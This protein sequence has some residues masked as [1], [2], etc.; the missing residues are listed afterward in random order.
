MSSER[1]ACQGG[2]PVRRTPM[3]GWPHF[4]ADEIA[5]V[6]EILASGK[7]NYWTG[8]VGRQ[9]EQ[10]YAEYLGVAHAIT[11]ANG[12]VALELG[13]RAFGVGPGDEVVVPAKTFIASASAVVAVGGVPVVADVDLVSQNLTAETIAAVLTPRTRAIV[14]VHLGG[15]PADMSAIMAF[16]EAR[17]LLVIEDC[18]Q[19][20]GATLG[21]R[22]VGSFG[23]CAAFSFCQDKIIT[24]GG[25][26]GMLAIRDDENAWQ[27][28]WA[29]KDH[30]K[31][32]DAVYHRAHPAGFRWLHESFGTNMR[33]PEPQAAIGR[34]QLAKLPVW[35]A[36]RAAHAE[37]LLAGLEGT[38]GLVLPVPPAGMEHAWY[39]CYLQLDLPRLGAGW[40]QTEIV[41]AVVAEGV[42][43]FAGSCSEIY[44]EKA[45]ANAGWGDATPLPNAVQLTQTSLALLVHPTL[46]ATDID[47]TVQAVRKVMRA[48]VEA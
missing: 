38:P 28:A 18:A 36:R 5:A 22:P 2:E 1:L 15:W 13:L 31:S 6:G 21:G 24:T 7:V 27:R 33:M 44:R 39:R 20:H 19:A 30:G 42:P 26:G 29:Y 47:D 17:G 45:F 9:F 12:T 40:G 35:R 41:E 8:T 25:E 23:H 46:S 34:L 37:R 11:L 43:C 4:A 14:V 16:A 48:A 10:E 32:Y 3:P